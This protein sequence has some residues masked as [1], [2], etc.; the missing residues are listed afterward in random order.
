MSEKPHFSLEFWPI[1][2]ICALTLASCNGS[3]AGPKRDALP[4]FG[5]GSP[6]AQV[7][8]VYVTPDAAPAPMQEDATPPGPDTPAAPTVVDAAPDALIAPEDTGTPDIALAKDLGSPDFPLAAP[9]TETKPDATI[10]TA[11]LCACTPN[12]DSDASPNPISLVSIDHIDNYLPFASTDQVTTQNGFGIYAGDR[13]FI[14][15]VANGPIQSSEIDIKYQHGSSVGVGYCKC[16]VSFGT[17]FSARRQFALPQNLCGYTGITL[18]VSANITS[19]HPE[20]MMRVT[21]ADVG[22]GNNDAGMGSDELWWYTFPQ[23]DVGTDWK[24][25]RIPFTAFN[26]SAGRGTRQ[27]DGVLDPKC[28]IAF[29]INYSYDYEMDCTNGCNGVDEGSGFI[30]IRNLTTY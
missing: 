12:A 9:D 22:C 8:T 25:F 19:P 20:G 3:S 10:C 28:I 17:W 29:E 11:P 30:N 4:P 15:N 16:I 6:D 23:E 1:I 21:I 26:I 13:N 14:I 2:G 5:F 27:N 7:I 24:T 18:D